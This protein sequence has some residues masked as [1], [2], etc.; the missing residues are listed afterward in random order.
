MP[1]IIRYTLVSIRDLMLSAGPLIVIAIA[2][3]VLAY[4]LLDPAPPK[5]VVLATGPERSAYEEF[6]RR[7][8]M[9]LKRQGIE[10]ILKGTTGSREN[11][12]LL[13][14][15]KQ[16]VELAFVQGGA[17]E[18]IRTPEEDKKKED[19]P[20]VVSLGSLFYEPV[21]LFY[22]AEVAKRINKQAVLT[23][24]PQ[25]RG[26]KVNVGVRGSGTPG[27][28]TRILAANFVDRD[29][30]KRSNLEDTPAVV[31]LLSG[32]LDAMALVSAPESQFVQMLLQTPGVKLFE[33]MHAEAYSRRYAFIR[34]VELP[35]GVAD[36]A[37]DVPSHDVPLIAATTSLVAREDTHPAVIQLFVQA[38]SRIHSGP[39]WI[40]RAGQF[41]T[42]QGSEFPLAKE[43]ERF[44]R[45]G[46]HFLQ[47]YLPFWLANLIDRMWVVLVSIIAI[48]IPLTRLVP[49][50]YEFRVRSRIFRWYRQLRSIEE[51]HEQSKSRPGELLADL[52]KLDHKAA[53]ITVPL[54]YA[55]E[56]YALRTHIDLVRE[57][58]AKAG[59]TSPAGVT[60]QPAK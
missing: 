20:S 53:H 6:G 2:A 49:P 5:R 59:G 31:A 21:W 12:R 9:E 32:E 46:P 52:D 10:V 18:T 14:D 26:L 39:G 55:D 29:E 28:T 13:R 47:R 30:L 56:L 23:Q 50:L 35:R 4:Y 48:L 34:P 15:G 27:L 60:P 54:S 22:R 41:P 11:L 58:L 8:A 7:Y 37:R 44:Y 17:S 3:L 51:Q 25:L 19:E 43:A 40:A 24:I 16:D 45:N 38:A 42:P 36:L 33:F 1:R 57:R